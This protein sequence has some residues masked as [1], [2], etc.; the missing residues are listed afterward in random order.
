LN[1][2]TGMAMVGNTLTATS[3]G[4]F[5]FS[6]PNKSM[7]FDLTI[8]G[9]SAQTVT[10][11]TNL[12][13]V[14]SVVERINLQLTGAEA[15]L[16]D[17][18]FLAFRNTTDTTTLTIDNASLGTEVTT[19]DLNDLVGFDLEGL[20]V[21]GG[22]KTSASAAFL[23]NGTNIDLTSSVTSGQTVTALEVATAVNALTG[24]HGVTAYVDDASKLHFASA[25]AFTLA[26]DANETGF[27]DSLDTGANLNAGTNSSAVTSGSLKINGVEV[28]S[29]SLTDSDAAVTT[30]NAAQ[31]NTG[32]TASL[33]ANGEIEL[34]S[35]SSIT[36]EAG[37]LAGVAT[38]KVLGINFADTTTNDGV[39]DAQT[40]N[41]SIKL[42]SIAGQ[43]I[44]V[45]VNS[46]G[47]DATGL[48][49]LNTDLGATVTGSALSSISVGSA[50]GA[51]EAIGSID[52]ALETINSTRS[53]LGAINNRLDFT[54]SNLS[55]VS[56][57]AS[58]AR[59]RIMDADFAS[60]TAAL[61]RSQVL[62]QASQAMLAQ[63][64]ARPQQVL[65]LL[66]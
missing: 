47:A 21:G 31:G 2:A 9:G 39:L 45:D 35:N 6:D 20:D 15:F 60:E 53:D 63:A 42:D 46:N 13:D 26:D 36:L 24:T 25:D 49:D 41:A 58:A 16:D 29:I 23:I 7:S 52:T 19:G 65:S 12:G 57:N 66:N 59:S 8:S 27:V 37:Q 33:D 14:A 3:E 38:G 17:N 10:L 28:T 55:N 50:A 62:Q 18:S 4:A 44:S 11:D 1:D 64:N 32:V 5:D 48:K 40:V 54:V 34:S 61:S 43:P 30:I 56:E 51:Q 22:S